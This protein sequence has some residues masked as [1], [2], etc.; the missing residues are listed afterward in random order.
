MSIQN[1]Q[2]TT[3][4]LVERGQ[5]QGDLNMATGILAFAEQLQMLV[6]DSGRELDDLNDTIDGNKD[7]I[8]LMEIEAEKLKYFH[9]SLGQ[10]KIVFSLSDL[11]AIVLELESFF[12]ENKDSE[13]R[14]LIYIL[15]RS[16]QEKGEFEFNSYSKMKENVNALRTYSN[17]LVKIRDA[18]QT[19][20]IQESKITNQA[21]K[22]R[23]FLFLW[24]NPKAEIGSDYAS[25]LGF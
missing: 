23:S 22:Y 5:S 4:N 16:D 11:E 15:D 12:T 24:S 19:I 14:R 8:T 2:P 20:E 17:N 18:K 7:K 3:P 9:Y 21:S 25:D 13:Y 10:H 1:G 6:N